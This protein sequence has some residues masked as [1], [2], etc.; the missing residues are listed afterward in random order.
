MDREAW[1]A[2]IHGVAKN[3]TWLSNWTE[4]KK[5][6]LEVIIIL[7]KILLNICLI[8][9]MENKNKNKKCKNLISV[10][11]KY[12]ESFWMVNFFLRG[13]IFGILF[14]RSK[15]Y[16]Q[17]NWLI[18]FNSLLILK[19][20]ILRRVTSFIIISIFSLLTRAQYIPCK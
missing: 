15:S 10:I 17:V 3:R 18:T 20:S 8:E 19:S 11:S 1:H 14:L 2:V 6:I 7:S 12:R 13:V 16:F 5:N 4:L 9:N